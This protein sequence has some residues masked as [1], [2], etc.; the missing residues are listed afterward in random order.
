MSEDICPSCGTNWDNATLCCSKETA[1][2]YERDCLQKEVERLKSMGQT[3]SCSLCEGYARERD[4]LQLENNRLKGD[5]QSLKRA[6]ET[7]RQAFIKSVADCDAW[8]HKAE[9]LGLAAKSVSGQLGIHP[10]EWH[11][12]KN[13]EDSY[14]Q[15]TPEMDQEN[16][17]VLRFLQVI[18]AY[19]KGGV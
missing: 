16:S 4:A 7:L 17:R 11:D 3:N 14:T 15:R 12:E 2:T 18:S 1:L 9:A 6:A 8:V 13:P 5:V 19:E 10:Q